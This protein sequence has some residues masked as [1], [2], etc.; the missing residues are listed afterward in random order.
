MIRFGFTATLALAAALVLSACGSSESYRQRITVEVETPEGLKTG[1]SV[2]EVEWSYSDA[3]GE[4]G[5]SRA[6]ARGEAVAVDLP[7]GQILFAL[8]RSE[9]DP[10]WLASA[11]ARA[12]GDQ[13]PPQSRGKGGYFEDH[14]LSGNFEPEHYP[15]LV[16]FRDIHNPTTME[17]VDPDHLE[18]VFGNGVR[19]RRITLQITDDSVT[20][21]I[22]K[23]LT[24][25]PGLHGSYLDGSSIGS[26]KNGGMHAGYFSSERFQ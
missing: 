7:D 22:E 19:I 11:A 18:G 24:W 20:S 4:L 15:M 1:S 10:D 25:L 12:V 26:A 13:I 14:H 9:T 17:I 2:S 21:G 3:F 16:R 5:G 23:R 6:G 8:R